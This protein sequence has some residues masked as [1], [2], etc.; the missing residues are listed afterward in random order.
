MEKR[1]KKR[2]S[3]CGHG[4][5][6]FDFKEKPLCT[7]ITGVHLVCFFSLK[8]KKLLEGKFVL[9]Q[10]FSACAKICLWISKC[11]ITCV[12]VTAGLGGLFLGNGGGGGGVKAG[13]KGKR[14][15]LQTPD[16]RTGRPG[17]WLRGGAAAPRPRVPAPSL[18]LGSRVLWPVRSVPVQSWR[19]VTEDDVTRSFLRFLQALFL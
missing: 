15:P 1:E 16:S 4:L 12:Y 11:I 18:E 14:R 3:E 8:K 19:P 7:L 17:K 10:K 13:R 9:Q 5:I 6:P 2:A